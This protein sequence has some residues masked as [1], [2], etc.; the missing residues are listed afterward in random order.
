[1]DVIGE[2]ENA[3]LSFKTQTPSII[4]LEDDDRGWEDMSYMEKTK[5]LDDYCDKHINKYSRDQVKK[6]FY[7]KIGSITSEHVTYD[8]HEH[9]VKDVKCL[10]HKE[11]IYSLANIT[12]KPEGV[13]VNNNI[14]QMVAQ[15]KFK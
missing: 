3:L 13:K 5:L 14:L 10:E 6:L 4:I 2:I 15:L 12:K 1:M 11:G 7:S 8:M 9:K